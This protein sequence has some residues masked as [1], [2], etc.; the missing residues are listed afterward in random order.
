[1]EI[2]HGNGWHL[3]VY[4][5]TVLKGTGQSCSIP[6]DLMGSTDA[7]P[8]AI[9]IVSARTRI[10][11]GDEHESGGKP[12]R[13]ADPGQRDG[14]FLQRLPQPIEDRTAK[15][16]RLVEKQ[17]TIVS[18]RDFARTGDRAAADEPGI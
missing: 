14:A 5:D 10:H 6:P 1:M 11:R 9:P 17:H 2:T 15:F 8:G 12:E 3:N 13:S 18:Q 4:V 7:F 16:R